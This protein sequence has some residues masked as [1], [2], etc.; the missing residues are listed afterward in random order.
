MAASCAD[1][2]WRQWSQSA[3]CQLVSAGGEEYAGRR[4]SD[5]VEYIALG[6]PTPL[7]V[8]HTPRV[9]LALSSRLRRVVGAYSAC[10]GAVPEQ[11]L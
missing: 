10:S 11:V 2:A 6:A 9:T 8:V 3:L 7:V 1:S 5:M 4:G